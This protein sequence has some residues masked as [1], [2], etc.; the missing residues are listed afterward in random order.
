[1]AF[2]QSI[3]LPRPRDVLNVRFTP[4]FKE[5]YDGIWD[6][7]RQEYQEERI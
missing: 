1:V 3:D 4:R 6:R 7:L 2:E 5:L